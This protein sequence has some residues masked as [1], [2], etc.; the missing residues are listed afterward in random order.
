MHDRRLSLARPGHPRRR[1]SPQRGDAAVASPAVAAAAS[2]W[3]CFF[4]QRQ[5]EGSR[6]RQKHPVRDEARRGSHGERRRPRRGNLSR[7]RARRWGSQEPVISLSFIFLLYLFFFFAVRSRGASAVVVD[8]S[9]FFF[10]FFFFFSRSRVW[11]DAR[12]MTRLEDRL[13]CRCFMLP[14]LKV[15]VA[16]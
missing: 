6:P 10:F 2:S 7:E 16:V 5:Q 1:L 12:R 13:L 8:A 15:G 4:G 14:K 11:D 3:R 9:I